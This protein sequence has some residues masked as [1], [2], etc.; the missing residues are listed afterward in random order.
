MHIL[1]IWCIFFLH[2]IYDDHDILRHDVEVFVMAYFM[3][4]TAYLRNIMHISCIFPSFFAY[5]CIWLQMIANAS[6]TQFSYWAQGPGLFR[7]NPSRRALLAILR[8][9]LL[10]ISAFLASTSVSLLVQLTGWIVQQTG[11]IGIL[12][13]TSI[14]CKLGWSPAEPG[15]LSSSTLSSWLSQSKMLS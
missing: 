15:L 8:H 2:K 7:V 12:P 6:L 1:C 14:L 4:I 9:A 10:T 3:H 11:S 13:T 5:L